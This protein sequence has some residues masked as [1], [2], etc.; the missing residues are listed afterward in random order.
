MKAT[1]PRPAYGSIPPASIRPADKKFR[2]RAIQPRKFLTIRTLEKLYALLMVLTMQTVYAKL[3]DGHLEVI[4]SALSAAVLILIL[5]C[6]RKK[7]LIRKKIL[8][9]LVL[10]NF[11][12]SITPMFQLVF[13]DS[14]NIK[15]TLQISA[16]FLVLFNLCVVYFQT[17]KNVIMRFLRDLND[18][19]CLVN[20]VSMF[21]YVFGQT[22]HWIPVTNIVTVRWG[23]IRRVSSFLGLHF[24]TQGEFY[25]G[26]ANG[27][28]TGIFAEAPMSS[29]MLSTALLLTIFVDDRKISKLRV[30]FL[31]FG[32]YVSI[33]TTGYIIGLSVLCIILCFHRFQKKI[34]RQSLYFLRPIL[35]LTFSRAIFSVYRNKRY[36]DAGSVLTRNQNLE[37]ALS[38]FGELPLFG[39][40]FKADS[41][42]ILGGDTSTFSQILQQGGILFFI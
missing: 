35:L 31:A 16:L 4:L 5:C 22:L 39:Y 2:L 9:N 20:V 10:L 38:R 25:H 17:N 15:A 28:F 6:K 41:I 36:L 26:F 1:N 23:G 21:F 12:F 18:M 32:I 40:G 7:I 3:A 11:L 27:R 14:V 42:G 13:L 33:S 30:A 34:I 29:F 37:S 24:V 19:I 8:V